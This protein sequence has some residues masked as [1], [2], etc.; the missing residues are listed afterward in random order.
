M[1]VVDAGSYAAAGRALGVP[2]S[3]LSRRII[4]LE[5]RLDVRLL[6]RSTRKLAVTEVGQQ[7]YHHCVAMMVEAEAA[8]ETID[9]SRS[10]PQ[11]LIRVSAP[12]ALVS[13]ELGPMIAR[14]MIANPL[15]KL[16]LDS[17]ARR[18]DVIGEGID[19][20]IR[21]RFPPLENS[22]L[23]MRVLGE[24]EHCIVG[25]PELIADPQ[26]KLTPADLS[27]LPSMD[28]NRQS[29]EHIWDLHGPNEAR[30]SIR[31]KPRLV[32]D[33][34]SQLLHAALQGVGIVQLPHMIVNDK[35]LDKTLLNLL[36]N[37]SATAGTVHAVFPSRRGLLPSVRSFIDFLVVEYQAIRVK[38]A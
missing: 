26:N 10:A 6:Q 34:M 3:K 24:R 29:R 15:V 20:A 7:Y 13:Y 27:S 33:D 2:K 5:E 1:Q 18:V 37:W 14:F 32:T 8:Q 17:T 22:E 16:E 31:H 30:A 28:V 36:P 12:P 4:A 38:N 19:V 25:S 23:A 21:V 9:R 11:G 35:L